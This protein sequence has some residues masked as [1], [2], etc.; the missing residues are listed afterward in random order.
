[1]VKVCILF[2]RPQDED[3]FGREYLLLVELARGMPRLERLESSR[4]L[5]GP[6]NQPYT[7]RLGGAEIVVQPL[8]SVAVAEGLHY[9]ML[10]LWF[11]SEADRLKAMHSGDGAR[12]AQEVTRIATGG[13]DIMLME[14]EAIPLAH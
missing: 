13:A 6:A 8:G 9:Q 14:T 3:T 11:A 10:E 4:L 1:M 2:G 7:E 5:G 12:F